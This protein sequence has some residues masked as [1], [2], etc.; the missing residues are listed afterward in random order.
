MRKIMIAAALAGATTLAACDT[1]S[2]VIQYTPSTANVLALQ[3]AMKSSGNTVKVSDFATADGVASPGCRMVGTLDVTG[4]K[5]LGQYLHD[6]LQTELFTAGV[7][8]VN[9]PVAITGKLESMKVNTFGTGSWTLVLSVAS[10]R[11]PTGYT[12]QVTHSFSTSYMATAAC[13]NA[14]NAFAPSVQE[15]I[16]QVVANPGFAKL[17]GKS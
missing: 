3:S 7:Y 6:A 1:T 11:D 13:Q 15:L 4:G 9:S 5:T 8:D 10:S 16:G 12:V 17:I 2:P 14:T